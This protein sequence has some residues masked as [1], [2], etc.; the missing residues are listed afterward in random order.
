MSSSELPLQYI[1]TMNAIFAAQAAHIALDALVL[2]PAD[3]AFLQ[4]ATHLTGGLYMRAAEPA[5]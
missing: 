3:S 2:G 4:Q 5:G 1:P